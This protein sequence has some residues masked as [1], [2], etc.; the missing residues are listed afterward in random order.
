LSNQKIFKQS[1]YIELIKFLALI[2]LILFIPSFIRPAIFFD[3]KKVKEIKRIEEIQPDFIFI[4]NSMLAKS[5]DPEYFQEATGNKCHIIWEGGIMS[6]VWYLIMKNV[7]AVSN[8]NP[9]AIFIFF[10]DTELTEPKRRA[11]GQYKKYIEYYSSENEKVLNRILFNDKGF[12]RQYE[13]SIVK[14]YPLLRFQETSKEEI[15]KFAALMIN[16]IKV[17]SFQD[18]KVWMINVLFDLKNFRTVVA[19]DE[20]L[21]GYKIDYDF[22]GALNNSLLPYIIDIAH[23]KKIKLIFIRIQRRPNEDGLPVQ[24]PLLIKYISDL[25]NY[26]NKQKIGCYDFT[27]NPNI[28]L[29]MYGFGDHLNEKSMKKFTEIFID[30]CIKNIK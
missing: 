12:N 28:T 11:T 13:D 14:F 19:D 24:P 2:L 29:D 17:D 15:S 8:I 22:N 20:N 1:R 23:K 7:I 16:S 10:R 6:S 4:G 25:K 18:F 3:D 30:T 26:M 9:K 5:I 21:E 27:G